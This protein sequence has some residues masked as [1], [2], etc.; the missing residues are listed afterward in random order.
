MTKHELQEQLKEAMKAK[1][2]VTRDTLRMLLSAIRNFEIEKGINY[3]ATDNDIMTVISRQVKM[4]KDAIEQFE[5]A[6]RDDL[7]G[8]ELKEMAVLE[9]F[10]PEQM[11]EEQ[12]K[13]IVIQALEQTRISSK[14]EM[15]KVMSVVMPQVKGKADG[16]LVSKVVKEELQKI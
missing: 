11:N 3:Q 9:G 14:A 8:K 5:S 13:K 10:L 15:G 16:N 2:E 12:V 1:D 6:G 7:V 4:R